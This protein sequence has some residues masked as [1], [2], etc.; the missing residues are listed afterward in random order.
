MMRHRHRKH[1]RRIR[2]V[3]RLPKMKAPTVSEI[4]SRGRQAARIRLRKTIAEKKSHLQRM[5][6]I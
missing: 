4:L 6:R 5:I 3:I 1:P 2:P